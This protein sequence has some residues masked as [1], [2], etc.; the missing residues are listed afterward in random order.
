MLKL[1]VGVR[2]RLVL[3]T[4]A[5]V[6]LATPQLARAETPGSLAQLAA[7]NDCIESTT[8]ALGCQTTAPGLRG[9]DDVAISPEVKTGSPVTEARAEVTSSR[10]G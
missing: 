2:G 8:S 10:P 3:A 7:P 4:T 6:V 1:K 5:I 9:P